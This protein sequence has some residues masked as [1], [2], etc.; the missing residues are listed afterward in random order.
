MT[1]TY[2]HTHTYAQSP[3]HEHA[4]P[5]LITSLEKLHLQVPELGDHA[6]G[7]RSLTTH[8]LTSSVKTTVLT[9][10]QHLPMNPLHTNISIAKN[11]RTTRQDT[12]ASVGLFPPDCQMLW[13]SNCI[14]QIRSRW[15][16]ARNCRS[17]RG[18]NVS[19][20]DGN[21]DREGCNPRQNL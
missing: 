17:H 5:F 8:Y 2:L 18:G 15:V 9:I 12:H 7:P 6:T 10:C 14:M 13:A 4:H 20:V 1:S 19:E 16:V 21:V 11:V 3:I